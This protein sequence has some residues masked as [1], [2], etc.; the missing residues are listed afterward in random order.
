MILADMAMLGMSRV[1]AVV[2]V[3]AVQGVLLGVFTLAVHAGDLTP[4]LAALAGASALL[5]GFVFPYIIFRSIREA[6]T[7]REMEPFVGYITSIAAGIALLGVSAWLSHRIT[8]PDRG[9]EPLTV[10]GALMTMFT[11]LF[12]VI[13]RKSAVTQVLGY[14]VVENGIYAFGIAAVGEVPALVELGIMLDAFVAVF[15]M[16]IA[17]YHINREFDHVDADRLDALKG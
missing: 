3:V 2:R 14:L 8:L 13:A 5:R 9:V 12:L 7:H 4:R 11:G 15:V 16:G 6:G 17:I 10:T 1:A